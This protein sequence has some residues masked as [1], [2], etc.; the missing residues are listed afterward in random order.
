MELLDWLNAGS[1]VTQNAATA[2]QP[3]SIDGKEEKEEEEEESEP[4][5]NFVCKLVHQPL[6][7]ITVKKFKLKNS[8][9]SLAD[10]S[11]PSID[12]N[13]NN[14]DDDDN[15]DEKEEEEVQLRP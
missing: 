2:R 10:R 11:P 5:A 3:P 14:D 9:L 4:A 13:D 8:L 1:R 6:R 7:A 15:A 12:D